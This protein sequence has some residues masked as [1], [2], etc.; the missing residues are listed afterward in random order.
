MFA[1]SLAVSLM[2][3]QGYAPGREGLA[4]LDEKHE[5]RVMRLGKQLRCAVCQGLSIADSPAS[6]ARAQLDKVRELVAEEKSDK[7]IYDYFIARYGEW[8]LLKPTTGGANSLLWVLPVALLAGGVLIIFMQARR[9]RNGPAEP[10]P[11]DP[12]P[13]SN[14]DDLLKKVRADLEKS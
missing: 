8:V 4:P 13:A 14:D 1:A 9:N 12:P 11:K 6:M 7:E 10:P 2:L 3:A 5:E